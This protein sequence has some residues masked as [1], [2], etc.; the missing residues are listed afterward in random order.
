MPPESAVR[1]V[2]AVLAHEENFSLSQF[3]FLLASDFL[4]PVADSSPDSFSHAEICC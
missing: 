3:A 4:F 1:P 2:R